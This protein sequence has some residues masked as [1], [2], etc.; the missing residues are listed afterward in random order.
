MFVGDCLCDD[1]RLFWCGLNL[2]FVIVFG[3]ELGL[4]GL[5]LCFC[6]C[7]V[8][9]VTIAGLGLCFPRLVFF[10]WFLNF[11]AKLRFGLQFTVFFCVMLWFDVWL[12]L[13]S[14]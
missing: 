8:R 1:L 11:V 5:T 9:Y 10:R 3:C 12:F 2:G 4:V 13:V 7:C 14:I 6:L